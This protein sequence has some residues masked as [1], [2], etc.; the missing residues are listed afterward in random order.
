MQFRQV[1]DQPGREKRRHGLLQ[2]QRRTGRIGQQ[3]R[4][5]PAQKR[6]HVGPGRGLDEIGAGHRGDHRRQAVARAGQDASG[7]GQI[8]CVVDV[9]GLGQADV[10]AVFP[11]AQAVAQT[12]GVGLRRLAPPQHVAGGGKAQQ[13]GKA[14]K[15]RGKPIGDRIEIV[16]VPVL[17]RPHRLDAQGVAQM[18]GGGGF[19]QPFGLAKGEGRH[20]KAK[21]RKIGS[22]LGVVLGHQMQRGVV[23][24]QGL[25]AHEHGNGLGRIP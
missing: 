17:F 7:Q 11:L 22:V 5:Q 12:H 6:F 14:A 18:D 9:H 10:Q 21:P 8:G 4:P 3:L 2:K 15:D 16:A 25:G 1:A 24:G 13:V 23:A 19:A 20:E